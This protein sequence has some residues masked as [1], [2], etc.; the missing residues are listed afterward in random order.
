MSLAANLRAAIEGVDGDPARLTAYLEDVG[1]PDTV[2]IRQRRRR[3]YSVRTITR[4]AVA[5]ELLETE[6]ALGDLLNGALD[7]EPARWRHAEEDRLVAELTTITTQLAE[8][9]NR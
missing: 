9:A 1:V 4:A 6:A 3:D 7:D 8:Q 5:E 2:L